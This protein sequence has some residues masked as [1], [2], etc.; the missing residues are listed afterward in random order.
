M[1]GADVTQAA[2]TRRL[3][4]QNSLEPLI[5]VKEAPNRPGRTLG[6]GGETAPP[7][8]CGVLYNDPEAASEYHEPRAT[9]KE[10]R[11]GTTWAAASQTRVPQA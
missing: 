7:C 10:S 5:I 8:A 1:G 6:G 3:R 11:G 2:S 4:C 9:L